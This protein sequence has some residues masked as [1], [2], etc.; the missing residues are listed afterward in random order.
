M[1]GL[2][3]NSFCSTFTHHAKKT[4]SLDL[5][6]VE[7]KQLSQWIRSNA[8]ISMGTADAQR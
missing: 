3:S 8:K 7:H 2:Q 6:D 4:F 5:L 1:T